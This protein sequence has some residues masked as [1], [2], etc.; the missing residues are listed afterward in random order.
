MHVRE[1]EENQPQG[2]IELSTAATDVLEVEAQMSRL[3]AW[4]NAAHRSGTSYSLTL[5]GQHLSTASGDE[6]RIACLEKLATYKIQ[7][8]GA[9]T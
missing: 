6:H 7:A 4:V 1:L 2:D 8:P 5:D 3:A 9:R